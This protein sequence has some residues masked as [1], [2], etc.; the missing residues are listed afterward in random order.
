[1]AGTDDRN[2]GSMIQLILSWGISSEQARRIEKIATS[3]ASDVGPL[4]SSISSQVTGAVDILGQRDCLVPRP[5]CP[6]TSC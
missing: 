2:P 3:L 6:G 4:S 5:R 1:M